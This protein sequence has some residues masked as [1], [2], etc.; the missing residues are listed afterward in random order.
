MVGVLKG[1]VPLFGGCWREERERG[2]REGE[3]L[4]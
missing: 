1:I 3:G 4:N 2:R